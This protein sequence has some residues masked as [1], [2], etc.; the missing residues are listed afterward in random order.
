MALLQPAVRTLQKM[1]KE[2]FGFQLGGVPQHRGDLL[3]N[4]I[5][6]IG[7]GSPRVLGLQFGRAL[8][9]LDVFACRVAIHIG[10]HRAV[11]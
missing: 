4:L 2:R 3:P 1:F 5:Q 8:A 9:R 10:L 11:A 6:R 7:A